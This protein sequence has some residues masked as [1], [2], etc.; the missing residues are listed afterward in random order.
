MPAGQPDLNKPLADLTLCQVDGPSQTS[1]P[2]QTNH[3]QCEVP[4]PCHKWSFQRFAEVLLYLCPKG[5]DG[6]R[7]SLH[8]ECLP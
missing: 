8:C 4:G 2:T 1:H 5:H 7:E 6:L 3:K